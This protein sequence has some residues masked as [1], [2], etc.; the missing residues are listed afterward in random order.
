MKGIGGVLVGGLVVGSAVALADALASR[1]TKIADVEIQEPAQLELEDGL[2][3]YWKF[4]SSINLGMDSSGFQNHGIVSSDDVTYTDAGKVNGAAKFVEGTVDVAVKVP[5]SRSLNLKDEITA[6]AWIK[7]DGNNTDNGDAIL[8]KDGMLQPF[9]FFAVL[10]DF[11]SE[12]AAWF[13]GAS[14]RTESV[15]PK[16]VWVHLAM[17]YDET[18]V[19]FYINGDLEA[20]RISLAGLNEDSSADLYIG[21]S[22]WGGAEDFSGLMDEVRLYNRVLKEIE[23]HDLAKSSRVVIGEVGTVRARQLRLNMWHT[24]QLEHT[25]T[26]PVVIMGPLTHNG[27]HA[28]HTRIRSVKPDSFTFK[29]EEWDYLDGRHGT[30][31]EV[32]YLVME[33]RVH[34]LDNGAIIQAG[35]TTLDGTIRTVKLDQAFRAKP[36]V[37][38]SSQTYADPGALVVHINRVFKDAF[39]ARLREQ[40]RNNDMMDISPH[41]EE[42]IGY[43]AIEPGLGRIGDQVYEAGLTSKAVNHKWY[44]ILFN[45]TFSDIPEFLAQKNTE[46]G[47]DPSAL[48]LRVLDTDGVDVLVEEEQSLDQETEHAKEKV[49]YL[50]IE[51]AGLIQLE[52]DVSYE[53]EEHFDVGDAPMSVAVGDVNRDGILDVVTANFRSDDV[54]ILLG[55]EEGLLGSAKSF[56]VGERPSSV[57]LGDVNGDGLVDLFTANQLSEDVSLLLGRGDGAFETEQRFRVGENPRSITSGDV[58][59]DKLLDLVTANY[60]S[61]DVSLLLR[62]EDGSFELERRFEVGEGPLSVMLEDLDGDGLLDVFTANFFT[63]DVS[64]LMGCSD[65]TLA[66]ELRFST[67]ENPMSMTLGDVNAD[68]M[69]DVVTVHWGTNAGT[70]TEHLSVLLGQMDGTFSEE[71]RFGFQGEAPRAVT[72]GD[73]NRDGYLDLVTANGGNDVSVFLGPG[74]GT[75]ER[76]QRFGAGD[77]PVSVALGDLNRDGSLDIVTA[78]EFSDDVSILLQE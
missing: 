66:E 6:A 5:H 28:A 1:F 57:K 13:S 27:G 2:V 71:E 54:S 44:T 33:S 72:S 53:T 50:A 68:G 64:V 20:E 3:G 14:V 31:E 47:D 42:E 75:F 18:I 60:V 59:G 34:V 61:D 7:L 56:A 37:L 22:P 4:D 41:R 52:R 16:G 40:E 38:A 8:S 48:R 12:V 26:D 29:I 19:K 35:K 78:N 49:G 65:G 70:G 43:V 55:E 11:S 25:Y 73:V 67:G 62:R 21:A 17:T 30:E 32:S 10:E 76:E 74:D 15:L 9:A 63:D 45:Q 51:P 69:L 39:K 23:I 24:V 58:N 77:L 36:V 46:K